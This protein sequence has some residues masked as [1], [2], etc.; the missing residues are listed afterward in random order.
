[1]GRKKTGHAKDRYGNW[2]LRYIE[3]LW[4]ILKEKLITVHIQIWLL[5]SHESF[6]NRK[7]ESTETPVLQSNVS[8]ASPSATQPK[9]KLHS[10]P[11]KRK[12]PPTDDGSSDLEILSPRK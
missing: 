5:C 1:M 6:C 11:K 9:S 2:N 8:H 7:D 12:S 4:K 10:L 3:V